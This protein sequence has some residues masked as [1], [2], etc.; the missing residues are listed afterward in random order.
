MNESTFRHP[1][2]DLLTAG[3]SSTKLNH[4]SPE[5]HWAIAGLHLAP[6]NAAGVGTVCPWAA[7]CEAVCLNT[8]GRGKMQSVQN[9]RERKTRQLMADPR[10]FIE[11]LEWDVARFVKAAERQGYSPALRLNMTSDIGWWLPRYMRN[12]SNIIQRW[13]ER[14]QF[15]DYTKRPV[16]IWPDAQQAPFYDLTFSHDPGNPRARTIEALHAGHNVSV[17]FDVRKSD[18]LPWEWDGYE[19]IDGRTHDYRFLDPK[20]SRVVGLSAL[21]DAPGSAFAVE[22]Y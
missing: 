8:A 17:V 9:A 1:R 15:Y 3:T 21:G 2:Y 18:D 13:H 22:S 4:D 10:D 20:G 16:H 19:V 12:G 14:V 7:T 11:R 5:G 6:A